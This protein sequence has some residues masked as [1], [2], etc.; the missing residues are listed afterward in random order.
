MKMR[1]FRFNVTVNAKVDTLEE[2][3]NKYSDGNHKSSDNA[4]GVDISVGFSMDMEEMEL[5]KEDYDA[6]IQLQKLSIEDG[7]D[8]RFHNFMEEGASKDKSIMSAIAD[9]AA[10]A[11]REQAKAE[12]GDSFQSRDSE[13]EKCEQVEI[14]DR[15]IKVDSTAQK[16]IDEAQKRYEDA[17][18]QADEALDRLQSL[19]IMNKPDQE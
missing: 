8:R 17:Q 13:E 12:F 9:Y 15:I 16:E 2:L 14:G 3:N 7:R 18:K 5:Y 10:T 11:I 19:K 1:G 6:I 4:K